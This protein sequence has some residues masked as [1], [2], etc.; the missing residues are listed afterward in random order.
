MILAYIGQNPLISL[1]LLSQSFY[2]FHIDILNPLNI[3][4]TLIFN[5]I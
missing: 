3:V 4:I 5:M 1:R 2:M